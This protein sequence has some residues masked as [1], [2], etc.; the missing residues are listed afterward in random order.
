MV[1]YKSLDTFSGT[2][3]YQAVS[4]GFAIMYQLRETLNPTRVLASAPYS[5]A[6]RP[7]FHDLLT[8]TDPS[9]LRYGL[10]LT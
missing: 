7:R 10:T 8:A 1:R 2:Y 6:L 9:F 3:I 4:S 5:G